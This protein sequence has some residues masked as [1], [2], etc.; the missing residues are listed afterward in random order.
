[1]VDSTN[2]LKDRGITVISNEP[3]GSPAIFSLSSLWNIALALGGSVRYA[4]RNRPWE[5]RSR[6]GSYIYDGGARGDFAGCK[7]AEAV[8]LTGFD[9]VHCCSAISLF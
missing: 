3:V 6:G 2:M 5:D 1:M 7:S 4:E 8:E 9:F